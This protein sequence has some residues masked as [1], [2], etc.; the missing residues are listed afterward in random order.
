MYLIYFQNSQDHNIKVLAFTATMEKAKTKIAEV[1]KEFI[2]DNE[3]KKKLENVFQEENTDISKLN[4]G[5]YFV[6]KENCIDVYMKTSKLAT[7]SGWLGS[8]Q[9]IDNKY[10]K[11]GIYSFVEFDNNML[12]QFIDTG[13]VN[14]TVI[15]K[16][17]KIVKGASMDLVLA[18]L[19]KNGFKNHLKPVKKNNLVVITE[20]ITETPK[21][22][23]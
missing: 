13:Y 5:Y 6:K 7:Q 4:D 14:K 19:V 10:E 17:T 2:I 21:S 11:V 22:D 18:Q 9:T 12:N 20:N 3:G 15:T 16:E 1:A 8:Y 23:N